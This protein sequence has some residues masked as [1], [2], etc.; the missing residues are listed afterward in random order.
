[1]PNCRSIPTAKWVHAHKALIY[2]FTGKG[3]SNPEDMAQETLMTVW[4]REDYQFDNEDDFLK[5]CY[6][7]ARNILREGYRVDRKHAAE[8]LDLSVESRVQ[9]IQ[10]LAG[11]EVSVFLE[12]VC[13][14]ADAE[15][16]EEEWAAIR[17]AIDRDR[18]DHPVEGKQRVRLH[19]ARK[20]LAK[21][22]G[23]HN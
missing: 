13:R 14:R 20:K 23:W 6:G 21:L 10:G 12:E 1:M 18:Q 17:D 3:V 15:L 19:R 22:T 7:F 4:S 11:N 5:V 9:R 16:Q 2:F 8:E